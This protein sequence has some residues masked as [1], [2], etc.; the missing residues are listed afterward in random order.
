MSSSSNV[1]P[2]RPPRPRTRSTST[3]TRRSL[4]E[5]MSVVARDFRR[6]VLAEDRHVAQARRAN[7][8][9]HQPP[10]VAASALERLIN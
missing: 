9:A 1:I 7:R 3:A 2:M 8:G 4:P 5:S 10:P 6:R